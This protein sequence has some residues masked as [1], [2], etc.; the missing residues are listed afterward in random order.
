MVKSA[1]EHGFKTHLREKSCVNIG[2]TKGVDIP[3]NFRLNAKLLLNPLMADHHVINYV[4]EIWSSFVVG[5]PT[6]IDKFEL[7]VLNQVFDNLLFFF[8]LSVVPHGKEAHFS[9]GESPVLI[10]G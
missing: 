1:E 4:I 8:G 9:V 5:T 7:A 2:V 10:F 3:T 6:A